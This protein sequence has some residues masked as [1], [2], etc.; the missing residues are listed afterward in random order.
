M[1]HSREQT[2]RWATASRTACES[3]FSTPPED[4]AE[5]GAAQTAERVPRGRPLCRNFMSRSTTVRS[6]CETSRR[7]VRVNSPMTASSQSS[8]AKTASRAFRFLGGTERTMRSWD[9]DSQISQLSRSLTLSGTASRRTRAPQCA[10]S[11]PTA[12]EN[13]PAPQS[14]SEE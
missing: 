6:W 10:A 12:E 11:S 9:S 8:A 2:L 4:L 13:P 1:T 5:A 14:V 3:F 7:P